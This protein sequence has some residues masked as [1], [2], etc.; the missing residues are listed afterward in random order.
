MLLA[1]RFLFHWVTFIGAVTAG[2]AQDGHVM[3]FG[4]SITAG[5]GVDPAQAFPA[6]I[7][8]KI[9]DTGWRYRVTNAG[10]SGE[11]SA[12]GL[13]RLDWLLQRQVDV[14]V[15]ELGAND[16][17][18]GLSLEMTESNLQAIIDKARQKNPQM[19]VVLAAM[20]IPP[21]MGQDYTAKFRR[22]FSALAAK[23]KCPLIPFLLE[24]VG[25]R[26]ELNQADGLHPTAEGHA[27]IAE[28][29][30]KTL[31]PLLEKLN[32]G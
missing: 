3:F 29:V 21:N 15:V 18:R 19:I 5:L 17:L 8:K 32:Q 30:W 24:G 2:C 28:T 12:G 31:K 25:D 22:L 13:R 10:L 11:T 26:P 23:N 16:G 7:E 20:E 6:L 9:S 27:I 14:L 1:I 4:N